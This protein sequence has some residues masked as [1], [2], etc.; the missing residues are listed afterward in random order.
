MYIGEITFLSTKPTLIMLL[1]SLAWWHFC[2][3]FSPSI[4]FRSMPKL[5]TG[6]M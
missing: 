5:H 1:C 6:T 2:L 3:R 4:K